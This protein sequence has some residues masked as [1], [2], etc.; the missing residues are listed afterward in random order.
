MKFYDVDQNSDEW[1]ALRLGKFTASTF[2]DLFMAKSTAGYKKAIRK[3]VYERLTGESPESFKNDWMD[4]GHELEPL[5]REAYE[6]MNFSKVQN[7]GFFE[8]NDWIGAS[9]DGLVDDDGQIEIKSPAYNTLIDYILS[10]KLP[11]EYLYQVQGQLLVT[12]RKWCDFI[13]YH[14]KL[15]LVVVR[16][17]PD[18]EIIKSIKA[19]LKT[20][21]ETAKD[22]I[23]TIKQKQ[24]A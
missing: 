22:M 9:P 12:G 5:A 7:G 3:I 8:Y 16:V 23:E 18:K 13:A 1:L 19:E 20:A 11:N 17:E 14:P 24:I 21:I 4:R 2:G 6:L 10:G 15:P